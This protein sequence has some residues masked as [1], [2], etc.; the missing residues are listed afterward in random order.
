VWVKERIHFWSGAITAGVHEVAGLKDHPVVASILFVFALALGALSLTFGGQWWAASVALAALLLV[1]L[2][3]AYVESQSIAR[4]AHVGEPGE[5]DE[6]LHALA[7]IRYALPSPSIIFS[8]QDALA[9]L[10]RPLAVGVP[11]DGD[12]RDRLARRLAY[13]LGLNDAAGLPTIVI[14]FTEDLWLHS[15]LRREGGHLLLDARGAA[16]VRRL[17]QADLSKLR[18]PAS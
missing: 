4:R 2:E 8:A 17:S 15:L 5:L 14:Q 7:A 3:G 6:V 13:G 18:K 12:G 10:G 16:V 1:L 9:I 11:E